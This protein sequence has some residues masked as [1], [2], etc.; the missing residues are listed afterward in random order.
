MTESES[1]MIRMR[2][3]ILTTTAE[4]VRDSKSEAYRHSFLSSFVHLPTISF[5]AGE[6]VLSVRCQDFVLTTE[7]VRAPVYLRG[8]MR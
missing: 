2:L 4:L 1:D 6:C 8:S 5:I 7:N 3:W